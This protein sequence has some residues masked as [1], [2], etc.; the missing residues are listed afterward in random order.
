M[1]HIE[2]ATDGRQF[3]YAP[4]DEVRGSAAWELEEAPTSVSLS[5]LWYT[6]GRG[7]QDIAV[8]ATH[9]FEAPG[10]QDRRDFELVIPLGPLSFSGTLISLAWALEIVAEPGTVSQRI[11]ILVSSTGQEIRLV[12]EP[13]PEAMEKLKRKV[14]AFKG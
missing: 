3:V 2:I 13:L 14:E 5:L 12:E 9:D 7:D 6:E 8:V 1:N 4:G 11:E 10:Q